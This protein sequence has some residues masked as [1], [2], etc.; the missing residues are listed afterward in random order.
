M[1]RQPVPRISP[2]ELAQRLEAGEPTTVLDVR[3]RSYRTS[4]S[5]IEGAVRIDPKELAE[6]HGTLPRDRMIVA[7][8]T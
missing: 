7:Y 5:K 3:G 1:A 6:R 4:D 8:C 2:S